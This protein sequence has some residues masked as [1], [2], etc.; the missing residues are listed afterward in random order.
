MH[1]D[2][3]KKNKNKV[4]NSSVEK[5][6]AIRL[7]NLPPHAA[8]LDLFCGHGVMYNSVYKDKVKLY[9]GVDS[10]KIHSPKI[11]TLGDNRNYIGE[12]DMNIF[13]VFDLD[14]Y[15]CPW[16]QLHLILRKLNRP[17]ATFFV[18][19]GVVRNLKY[20]RITKFLFATEKIPLN[21]NYRIK[22]INRWYPDMFGTML[23]SL[24]ERYHW[25]T[26]SATYF[27][28]DKITSYYW[29]LKMKYKK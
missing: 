21:M 9:H 8:V 12:N 29:C 14:S 7:A 26:E 23:L 11:C 19:D 3:K 15:G 4:D 1:I 25:G 5:K 22:M 18:T 17:Q 27:C 16:E 13:D 20:G 2:R 10:K 28:N 6:I 24:K